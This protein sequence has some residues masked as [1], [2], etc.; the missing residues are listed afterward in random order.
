MFRIVRARLREDDG[1]ALIV[2][3]NV[4]IIAIGLSLVVAW[5]A[6]T[7][8][9]DSGVDRQRA[10]SVNAAEAGVDAAFIAL[11]SA[12][13]QTNPLP[14][15][16]SADIGPLTVATPDQPVVTRSIAYTDM[17][18]NAI[19]DCN[20][21]RANAQRSPVRAIITA[22][23]NPTALAGVT[24]KRTRVFQALVTLKPVLQNGFQNAIFA[25]SSLTVKNNHTVLGNQGDDAN[26][27]SNG[28][29]TC[30][31]GS[32]QS[33]HG[34]LLAQG[35][36]NFV[37]KCSV[38]GDIWANG[39]VS[40]G[41][42]LSTVGGQ[43]I[44]STSSVSLA[45]VSNIGGNIFAGTTISPSCPSPKCTQHL[46]Q[47]PPPAQPFPRI[48][49]SLISEWT[50]PAGSNPPGLGYNT[51]IIDNNCD[52]G[53]VSRLQ[54]YGSTGSGGKVLVETTCPVNFTVG[55]AKHF[56]ISNDLAIFADGGY[57]SSGQVNMES[58]DGANHSLY[59]IVPSDTS[60]SC[61]SASAPNITTDQN[62]GVDATIQMMMYTPCNANIQNHAQ[63]F[64]QIYAGGTATID[65]NFDMDFRPLPVVGIDPASEP[66]LHYDV[67]VT[68]K[69]EVHG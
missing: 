36:V 55:N 50:T 22:T 19:T 47:G 58:G 35:S 6:V 52:S 34:K 4:M 62:F 31:T 21:L 59:W 37:G 45:D 57:T 67:G 8:N 48:L 15:P 53:L 25:N 13:S 3:L 56:K 49:K 10:V 63:Q 51:P 43:V 12:G 40:I 16:G 1:I 64:G 11:Q 27:Y 32:L 44:S 65:N 30:P 38:T 2:A 20:T 69:R 9:T 66:L 28:D 24:E 60:V 68:Y 26:I 33:Y 46:V 61:A 54:G 29:V 5:I 18:G 39:S 14:C 41:H 7:T 17:Q 23:A 42:N